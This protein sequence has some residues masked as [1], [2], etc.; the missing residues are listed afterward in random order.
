VTSSGRARRTGPAAR[1][2]KQ[3]EARRL[4]AL[5][6]EV[7]LVQRAAPEDADD[8]RAD[9]EVRR[10]FLDLR[11][12][13][14]LRSYSRRGPLLGHLFTVLSIA[15][16][17]AGLGASGLAA[18]AE[19]SETARWVIFALGLLVGLCTAVNQILRPAQRSVSR[20]R[21]ANALRHAAWVFLT[22][23]TATRTG[24]PSSSRSPRS[25]GR[26]RASTS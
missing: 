6:E 9:E 14:R 17:V 24:R 3:D 23:P 1:R 13:Q 25:S 12:E 2:V 21:A 16:I 20:Y 26:P 7:A 19:N 5:L 18:A 15:S 10:L 8:G 11:F 22:R 4:R